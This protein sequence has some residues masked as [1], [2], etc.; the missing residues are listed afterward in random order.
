MPGFQI[1]AVHESDYEAIRLVSASLG[2]SCDPELWGDDGYGLVAVDEQAEVIGWGRTH[3]WDPHDALAPAGFYLGGV[4]VRADWQGHGIATA[5][6][7]ARIA[8]VAK[9]SDRIYCVVN[10]RNTASL[11]L[12]ERLGLYPIATAARFGSVEFSGGASFL[13]TCELGEDTSTPPRTV[14]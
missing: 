6:S 9:R 14:A 5:L 12:Q 3:W 10:A 11:K 13:L 1:R 4:E 8:W 2:H 7:Q